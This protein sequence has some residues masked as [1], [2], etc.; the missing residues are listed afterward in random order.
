MTDQIPAQPAS[1]PPPVDPPAVTASKRALSPLAAG[2][3][4]LAVGASVVGGAWLITAS[5][6]SEPSTFT[7]EGTFALTEDALVVGD[8]CVGTGGYD[9]IING[10]AV[11]VY[12]AKGDVIATGQLGDS[13]KTGVGAC[14][15]KVAVPDVPRGE[16]FYKVEVSHRGTIQLSAEEAEN[17][18]LAASLG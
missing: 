1:P 17:G 6:G 11:T 4:G 5:S 10:A 16:R 15:F 3:L 7:L 2:L 8:K 14:E 13:K 12:G 18:E 9:D